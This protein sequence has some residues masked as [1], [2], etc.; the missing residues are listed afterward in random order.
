MSIIARLQQFYLGYYGRPADPGGLAYWIEQSNGVYLNRDHA[1]AAAF[2]STDQVEF[3]NL[4]SDAPYIEA[5]IDQVYQN[6]FGRQAELAGLLFFREQYENYLAE[7]VSEDQTRAFLIARVIDGA[8]GSDRVAINNKVSVAIVVTDELKLKSAAISDPSEL[9]EVQEYFAGT[10]DDTWRL[11]ASN[12]ASELV[13]S[14]Q[15]NDSV[16]DFMN[17]SVT[18]ERGIIPMSDPT[19]RL[20]YSRGFLLEGDT[21]EGRI[22]NRHL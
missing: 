18:S 8:S 2:G 13:A 12:R 1:L 14:L 19:A 16:A 4:Y 5:F 15:A 9:E 7:G 6:L 20:S 3:R 22:S 11:I 17:V 10:G 21:N